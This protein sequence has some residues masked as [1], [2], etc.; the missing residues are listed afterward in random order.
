[1]TDTPE[2]PPATGTPGDTPENASKHAPVGSSID[3]A[4]I[5]DLVNPVSHGFC[6]ECGNQ[7]P[8]DAGSVRCD[9]CTQKHLSTKVQSTQG[10]CCCDCGYDLAGLPA[11]RDCPECSTSYAKSLAFHGQPRP[12]QKTM[13]LRLF[14]PVGVGLFTFLLA[15]MAT[16]GGFFGLLTLIVVI[17]N[18]VNLPVL[19]SSFSN[20]YVPRHRRGRWAKNM[21]FL[22]PWVGAAWVVGAIA[23]GVT[24]VAPALALGA[25]LIIAAG[26]L[27]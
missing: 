9:T 21:F 23:I 2:Q 14:W 20:N 3:A 1:M 10:L 22:G 16:N 24:V 25:C 13:A 27:R 6:N 19:S 11:G 18:A 4:L 17:I 8:P 15:V 12:D 5:K 7:L 26:G